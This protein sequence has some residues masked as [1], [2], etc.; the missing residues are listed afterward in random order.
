MLF[1]RSWIQS[2][3]PIIFASMNKVTSILTKSNTKAKTLH[4]A[5]PRSMLL[6]NRGHVVSIYFLFSCSAHNFSLSIAAHTSP[7]STPSLLLALPIKSAMVRITPISYLFFFLCK[8]RQL[9]WPPMK[10][11]HSP[12]TNVSFSKQKRGEVGAQTAKPM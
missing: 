12:V 9:F 5:L 1:L 8:N 11:T 2:I 3:M 10:N 6:F 4:W 7:M